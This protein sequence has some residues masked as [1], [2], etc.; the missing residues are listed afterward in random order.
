MTGDLP[1][2]H[3]QVG[4]LAWESQPLLSDILHTWLFPYLADTPLRF[5][6]LPRRA[7][8]ELIE[9]T[10]SWFQE[11]DSVC[12]LLGQKRKLLGKPV[13]GRNV[14][15]LLCFTFQKHRSA[16]TMQRLWEH[17]TCGFSRSVW[18]A[19]QGLVEQGWESGSQSRPCLWPV[20]GPPVRVFLVSWD[21]GGENMTSGG[22]GYS[23]FL[24][25]PE[26][27]LQGKRQSLQQVGTRWWPWQY[28]SLS[29]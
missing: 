18:G 25:D 22:W 26:H 8:W 19:G 27:P 20:V 11:E 2:Q 6:F 7:F 15:F 23:Y 17:S 14:N 4:P 21:P 29:S 28:C 3:V 10:I 16:D 5:C 24:R 1:S 13:T 9:I 12:L